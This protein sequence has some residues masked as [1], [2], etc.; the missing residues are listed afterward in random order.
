M[1]SLAWHAA[2]LLNQDRPRCRWVDRADYDQ[3]LEQQVVWDC[4]QGM[5]YGQSFC[6]QFDIVDAFLDYCIDA[7]TADRYIRRTYLKNRRDPRKKI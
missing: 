5:N 2:Q 6:V 1:S 7:D 4:L 3:W